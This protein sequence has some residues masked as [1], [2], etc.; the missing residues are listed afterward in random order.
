[1]ILLHVYHWILYFSL[2][3][4]HGIFQLKTT[5]RWLNTQVQYI[6]IFHYFLSS[7]SHSTSWQIR[8]HRPLH[9]PHDHGRSLWFRRNHRTPRRSAVEGVPWQ[10][11]GQLCESLPLT[12]HD[13]PMYIHMLLFKHGMLF[14]TWNMNEYG[15]MMLWKFPMFYDVFICVLCKFKPKWII[16]PIWSCDGTECSKALQAQRTRND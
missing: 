12:C 9:R 13:M 15:R 2:S 10:P 7:S 14:Q 5:E 4:E 8:K 1:M 3:T 11:P 6:S 16:L